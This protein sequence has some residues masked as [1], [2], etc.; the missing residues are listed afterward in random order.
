MIIAVSCRPQQLFLDEDPVDSNPS[1]NYN[2]VIQ[3]ADTYDEKSH[4]ESRKDN[5]TIGEF[6]LIQPDGLRR[7]HR[8]FASPGEGFQVE[9]KYERVSDPL[10]PPRKQFQI[11]R[12]VV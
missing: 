12:E 7:T 10:P 8:Y 1:Y 5:I 2:Y 9:V 11:V 6:S 3:S 4:S